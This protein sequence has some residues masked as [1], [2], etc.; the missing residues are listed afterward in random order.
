MPNEL[1]VPQSFSGILFNYYTLANFSESPLATTEIFTDM[2]C[3]LPPE[4]DQ[5]LCTLVLKNEPDDIVCGK[6]NSLMGLHS[7]E[8][9]S[10]ISY[11][12]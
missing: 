1:T 3:E 10:H 2:E 9:D 12:T 6:G 7:K 4:F 5:V 8:S 11:E